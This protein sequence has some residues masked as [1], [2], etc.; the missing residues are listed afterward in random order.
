MTSEGGDD[1]NDGLSPDAAK[2]TIKAA[3]AAVPVDTPATIYVHPGTYHETDIKIVQ[4]KPVRILGSSGNPEDVVLEYNFGSGWDNAT[5][6]TFEVNCSSAVIANLTLDKNCGGN[7]WGFGSAVDLKAGGTLSNCVIRASKLETPQRRGTVWLR[8]A[9]SRVTR[10]LFIENKVT[11]GDA[12]WASEDSGKFG[13]TLYVIKGLVDN[14]VFIGNTCAKTPNWPWAS[15]VLMDGGTLVNCSFFENAGQ[16]AG[17]IVANK[18]AARIVNT[19]FYENT[20]VDGSKAPMKAYNNTC[21]GTSG[22]SVD[23]DSCFVNCAADEATMPGTG[24]IAHLTAA[25]F[26]DY[27]GGKY[28]P[29]GGGV[30]YNAGTIENV[31][32]EALVLDFAG[33]PRKRGG[34]VDIGA[35]EAPEAGLRIMVR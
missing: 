16:L 8:T 27:A 35:F 3:L 2:A 22:N 24:G 19:A 13:S 9:G 26:K 4:N 1:A 32:A 12:Q 15:T 10:C 6:C 25:A 28:V 5:H 34:K 20:I 21:M 29:V 18:P 30:L 7:E 23:D 11:A 14:C 33:N 17:A 31:P